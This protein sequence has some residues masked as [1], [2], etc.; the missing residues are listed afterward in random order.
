MR[1][2]IVDV[3]RVHDSIRLVVT[4]FVLLGFLVQNVAGSVYISLLMEPYATVMSPPVILQNGTAGVSTIYTNNTSAKVSVASMRTNE[5]EDFADLLSNVDSSDDIG[6][7][8]NFTAQ[9][10]G[11]DSIFD[12]LAEESVSTEKEEYIWISGNDD[13]VRKLNKSDPGGTEILRWDTGTSHPYGCEFRIENGNEYIYVTDSGTGPDSDILMKF[14]ASNG[15]EVTRWDISVYSGNAEGLTWN[16]SR[17][18]IADGIDQLIYQVD[19]ADPTVAERSFS[20]SGHTSCVGLAWDGLYIWTVDLGTDKVYQIDVYGNIQTSWDFAPTDPTGLAYDTASGHLWITGR[21]PEYLYEYYTNG[22][23]INNWDLTGA[24]PQGCAFSSVDL[25]NYQIDLEVKWTNVDYDETNEYL[26]IYGGTMGSENITVDAWNG[27]AWQNLFNDLASGWNN[28]SI[29]SY[30]TSVNSTI[31]F[32][33]S[34]EANDTLQD[35]WNIDAALLH[36]WTFVETTYD[37]VLRVNN[38]GIDSREIRLKMYSDSSI[39]RLQNCTIYFHNS[40]DGTSS[41][42]QIEN[43]SYKPGGDVGSWYNLTSLKTIYIAM[44]VEA[45]STATSYVDNYLEI[46]IPGTTTYAQYII[47]F[48]IM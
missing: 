40:T 33:G 21:F 35:T 11:P 32:K 44:T 2:H 10:Y 16:G 8:S 24:L 45:N 41:Q 13:L 37:Y 18:F 38:T 34:N 30:L 29:S 46:R 26:C 12:T 5:T 31:R 3:H 47:R 28:V 42:I 9:Q 7:H 39:N 20:Y 17:W 36:T 25:T 27:S 14:H 19:P 4:L 1:N 6:T 48:E 15:T 23:E 43:G 22:T